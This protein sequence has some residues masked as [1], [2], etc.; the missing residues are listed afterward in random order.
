VYVK[1]IVGTS[2][3]VDTAAERA[4]APPVPLG[5]FMVKRTRIVSSVQVMFPL[6]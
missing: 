2:T 3:S 5:A 6:G 1:R 4:L